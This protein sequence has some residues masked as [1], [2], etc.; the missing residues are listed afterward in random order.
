MKYFSVTLILIAFLAITGCK[1]RIVVPE[2][3]RVTTS[4]GA[5]NCTAGKTC[6]IDVVDIFFDQT[7][8]AQ[9]AQGYDFTGWQKRDRGL[10]G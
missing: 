6:D 8:T 1:I 9:P 5:Y 10:C 7:F 3:G 4:S 2:G